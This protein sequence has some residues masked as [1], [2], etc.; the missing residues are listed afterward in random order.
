MIEYY[1]KQITSD[2]GICCGLFLDERKPMLDL[3]LF[4]ACA[5]A[6]YFVAAGLSKKGTNLTI[7]GKLQTA[8]IMLLIFSMGLNMGSND[9][10]LQNLNKIGL[11]ALIF[12]L[13]IFV[14]SVGTVS[15]TRRF[16]GIDR[17]GHIKGSVSDSLDKPDTELAAQP[18][19]EEQSG[20]H[21]VW[22]ILAALCIGSACGYFLPGMG[23]ITLEQ[24]GGFC[25]VIIGYGLFLLLFL[26]GMGFGMEEGMMDDIKAA[27]L[28]ILA[29]PVATLVG[30]L[31]GAFVC[32]MILPVSLGEGLA[33]GS[34]FGWYSMAPVLIMEKGFVTASAVSFMHN[35]MREVLS[36][37]LIPIVAKHVGYVE[38]CGMPGCGAADVCLPIVAKSTNSQTSI[39]SFVTGMLIGI[40]VPVLVPLF[41]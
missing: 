35:L 8:M 32:A 19:A 4:I 25:D 28:R 12:T 17:Y 34:G 30:T 5:V 39:Y 6:G 37:V 9:E 18:P 15:I 22:F 29:I 24:I 23:V 16:L 36:L 11:Y 27:G 2:R 41:L 31:L 1:Q 14:F 26:I 7:V 38:V 13:F 33:I 10:I 40:P 20:N 21:M 3:I